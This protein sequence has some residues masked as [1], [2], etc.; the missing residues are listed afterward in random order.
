M[1]NFR[2]DSMRHFLNVIG[3]I[4]GLGAALSL[5]SV[6]LGR[7][8]D[9]QLIVVGV[10]GTMMACAVGMAGVMERLEELRKAK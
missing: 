5:L 6:F 1:S 10:F 2:G 3:A 4:A 7:G 9:L 8:T